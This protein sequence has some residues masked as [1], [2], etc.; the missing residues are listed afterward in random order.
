MDEFPENYNLPKHTGLSNNFR[1][2]AVKKFFVK[3][4][5]LKIFFTKKTLNGFIEEV[6]QTLKK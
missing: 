4:F 3:M 6:Y 2:P 1:S 5:Y